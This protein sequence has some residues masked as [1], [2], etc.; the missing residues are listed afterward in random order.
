[1]ILG[2]CY[3]T[4]RFHNML[5]NYWLAVV[6]SSFSRRTHFH[7]ATYIIE[8]FLH[9]YNRHPLLETQLSP[10]V[11][12]SLPKPSRGKSRHPSMGERSRSVTKSMAN[13]T[14]YYKHPSMEPEFPPAVKSMMNV[15]NL[16]DKR[17]KNG[18]IFSFS[19]TDN[20]ISVS[21]LFKQ[22]VWTTIILLSCGL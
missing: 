3:L 5:Q 10:A 8:Y 17:Q 12:Q 21:I 13:L 19:D 11:N 6:T 1:M 4:F 2:T 7:G 14:H 9:S 15:T 22:W 18:R 16:T 20:E